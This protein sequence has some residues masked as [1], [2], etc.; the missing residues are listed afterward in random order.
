M[1]N[2]NYT[3]NSGSGRYTNLDKEYNKFLEKTLRNIK[4]DDDVIHKWDTYNLIM[5]ELLQLGKHKLFN[6]IKYR[7]TD[8]ENPNE[9]MIDILDRDNNL[10]GFL[11]LVRKRIE[12]YINDDFENKFY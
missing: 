9:V 3:I 12:E 11:W 5:T 1:K 10:S 6:E 7:L 2:F 8:G 4:D